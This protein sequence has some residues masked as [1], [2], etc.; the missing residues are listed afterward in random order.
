M[1][2]TPDPATTGSTEVDE[3]LSE[4]LGE[5]ADLADRPVAEH[6]AVFERAHTTLRRSL[7]AGGEQA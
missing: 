7:D 6:V 3:V 4:I 2:E 5:T 1:S